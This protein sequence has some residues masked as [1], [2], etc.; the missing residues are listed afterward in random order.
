M[1]EFI[2]FIKLFKNLT[3]SQMY[4]KMT[5]FFKNITNI[6]PFDNPT[7]K[8]ELNKK[9]FEIL[10]KMNELNLNMDSIIRQLNEMY[11]FIKKNDKALNFESLYRTNFNLTFQFSYINYNNE[12]KY[13]I[14]PIDILIGELYKYIYDNFFINT[15]IS[16]E[17][18]K[19]IISSLNYLFNNYLMFLLFNKLNLEYKI[20]KKI[21]QKISDKNN[22]EHY[23]LY[24]IL[25]ENMNIYKFYIGDNI[26]NILKTKNTVENN[27]FNKF[28][29]T[30]SSNINFSK[31]N[32]FNL[33]EKNKRNQNLT[34]ENIK[35]Y[36][37]I[38]PDIQPYVYKPNT[39]TL[40][41]TITI[42]PIK[43][44]GLFSS[45]KTKPTTSLPSKP[46]SILSQGLIKGKAQQSNLPKRKI[47]IPLKKR[48]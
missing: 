27:V 45:L 23:K 32:I 42:S 9:F 48:Y 12:I 16:K 1:T 25:M 35:S 3:Q 4:K 29:L 41:Q 7:K 33:S 36:V 40:H 24:N 34:R 43:K 39:I 19:N 11:E 47:I 44:I 22:I 13:M 5:N 30:T 21:N 18:F 28:S 17:E 20:M 14:E 2:E 38:T 15:K 8:N 10:N 31:N 6:L 46:Q 37:Y 26:I